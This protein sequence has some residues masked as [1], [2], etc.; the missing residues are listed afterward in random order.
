MNKCINHIK[1]QIND[2]YLDHITNMA[3]ET[4]MLTTFDFI[5]KRANSCMYCENFKKWSLFS[6]CKI[7]PHLQPN[8]FKHTIN[9]S[10]MIENNYSDIMNRV[11]ESI[12]D[13]ELIIPLEI[14][15]QIIFESI[16]IYESIKYKPDI[17]KIIFESKNNLTNSMEA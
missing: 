3:I 11:N 14:N 6:L 1:K 5:N 15:K 9:A 17:E 8:C 13:V 12:N 16:K 2:S 7:Y 4:I 10:K